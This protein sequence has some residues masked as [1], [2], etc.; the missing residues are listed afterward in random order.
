MLTEPVTK[1]GSAPPITMPASD[2]DRALREL[3]I[4]QVERLRSFKLHVV[5][6]LV[7][8]PVLGAVWV[9]TEYF[10]ERTWPDRFA[11]APDVAGTWDPWLFWA[12]GI[13][14]GILCVHAFRT[15]AH[16]PPSETE[17]ER[18]IERLRPR[19]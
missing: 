19:S 9:L 3:A 1:N 10:E 5:A 12:V 18:E 16:R 17:I 4:K 2:A 7:G 14:F 13:W 11:S 8:T 6:F 15:F